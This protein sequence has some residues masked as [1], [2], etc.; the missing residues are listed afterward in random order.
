MWPLVPLPAAVLSEVSLDWYLREG[1]DKNTKLTL[2]TNLA[3]YYGIVAFVFVFLVFIFVLF[4]FVW[5]VCWP[6]SYVINSNI[7]LWCVPSISIRH[8]IYSTLL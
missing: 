7:K 3:Q 6:I 1:R 8:E 2:Y 4:C 5:F